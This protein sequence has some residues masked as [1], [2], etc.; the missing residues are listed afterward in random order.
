M[1]RGLRD[2][3]LGGDLAEAGAL[4][5]EETGVLDFVGGMGDG[6]A[7]AGGFGDGAGVGGAFSGERALHLGE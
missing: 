6:T 3:G 4:S 7:G 2:T 1:Q 5:F